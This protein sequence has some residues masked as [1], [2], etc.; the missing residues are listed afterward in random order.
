MKFLFISPVVWDFYKYRDQ[1]LRSSLAKRDHICVYL[2]PFRYKNWQKGSVRLQSYCVNPVPDGVNVIE[3]K[4]DLKK[5]VFSFLKE[6][7]DNIRQI[8]KYKPEVVICTDHLMGSL[9]CIYCNIKGVKFIFDNTDDWSEVENS[10]FPK[11]Y[12]KY[13][14]RPLLRKHSYAITSTSHDQ[15]D[16]FRKKNKNTFFI[17]NGKPLEFIKS[18]SSD[19]QIADSNV[20][21]F[22]GS[23]RN[24]YDFDLMFD[25]FAELPD[26]ELN[27]YGFGEMYD[28][29][30]A[31]S[32]SYKNIH[33]KGNASPELL[34]VLLNETAF[35]II[36]LKNIKLNHSTCPIKLFDYWC[37][38]KAVIASP[39]NEIKTV[40]KDNVIY[41][42][43][44]NE[45]IEA[46]K[47]LL[48]DKELRNCL[49]NNGFSQIVSEFNYDNITEE[50]LKVVYR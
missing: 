1:E 13:F 2:N 41:A 32:K 36:P 30:L 38:K 22:I 31:K 17:P 14:S 28:G 20:V 29:L 44:K 47:K 26:I 34:P 10:F 24:W 19:K 45:F 6:S 4:T 12:W 21:N 33:V 46:V 49:G 39:M 7:F 3:R 35:G 8:K 5:S 42:S 27:I 16:Y 11:Y 15:A 18:L 25:V 23:L 40:A 37:A 43:G 9:A 48:G 50:F